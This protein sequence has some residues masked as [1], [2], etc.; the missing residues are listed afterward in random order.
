MFSTLDEIIADAPFETNSIDQWRKYLKPGRVLKREGTQFP[1]KKEE[2]DWSLNKLTIDPN[3]KFTKEE[4][5]ELVSNQR[6][7]FGV[8]MGRESYD[9]SI[10]LVGIGSEDPMPKN[11]MLGETDVEIDVDV[12]PQPKYG[13]DYDSERLHHK[14][15]NSRYEES[16]TR[17]KGLD[18]QSHFDRDTL[19][20]SRTSTH[21]AP[22][23][24]VTFKNHY[25]TP[26]TRRI[27]LVEEIQT[28]LHSKA[29]KKILTDPVTG[30]FY[31]NEYYAKGDVDEE[32][33]ARLVTERMGYADEDAK[34]LAK[35]MRD[36]VKD[37]TERGH[38]SWN[39]P[40]SPSS[41][42]EKIQD[43]I[44]RLQSIAT[45]LEER[46]QNA[47][48][49]NPGD[50][51]GLE[52]KKQ[53]LNAVD[54]DE[55]Y[56]AITRGMDQISRYD[57]A[58]DSQRS[59]G[60][61]KMYDEVYPSELKKLAKRYGATMEDVEISVTTGV[62]VRPQSMV[63][64]DAENI[65]EAF[66]MATDYMESAGEWMDVAEGIDDYERA[67]HHVEND[68][69]G[70]IGMIANGDELAMKDLRFQLG[71]IRNRL[72]R[73][74]DG[75]IADDQIALREFQRAM[76]DFSDVHR[77]FKPIYEGYEA[78]R[79]GDVHTLK[80]FPAMKL[81]PEVKERIR[82]LG[83]PQFQHGGL[84]RPDIYPGTEY[85]PSTEEF[86]GMSE[87]D[88]ERL[89]DIN[90][91]LSGGTPKRELLEGMEEAELYEDPQYW[92]DVPKHGLA[93]LTSMWKTLD[94]E[95]GEAEWNF[96]AEPPPF[97]LVER[98]LMPLS[99]WKEMKEVADRVREEKPARPGIIDETITMRALMTEIA[100]L[101]RDEREEPPQYA[102]EA[103]ERS[104]RLQEAVEEGM[105]LDPAVGFPQR[106]S[107]MMGFMLGQIPSPK[108][109]TEAT[110]AALVK[111]M[112][113]VA[114][115][116]PKA[117]KVGV[118]APLE[119]IDPTIRPSAATY[120]TGAAAGTGILYGI[121]SVAES[122]LKELEEK[123]EEEPEELAKGGSVTK[124]L[125]E[126]R[127]MKEGVIDAEG[128]FAAK[129]TDQLQADPEF[130]GWLDDFRS[131]IE[132]K[133][134][135]KAALMEE[136][137]FSY[138]PGDVVMG[139]KYRHEILFKTIDTRD[140]KPAY[141][142]KN[143]DDESQ[144]VLP[145]RGIVGRF[146]GPK[147]AEL[148]QDLE[149]VRLDAMDEFEEIWEMSGDE[150][151]GYDL[152]KIEITERGEGDKY[153][154]K[155]KT[156]DGDLWF[157]YDVSETHPGKTFVWDEI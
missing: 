70:N 122:Q 33:F 102:A 136:L 151:H 21:D 9:E 150:P 35:G 140:G 113:K 4:L 48:Y 3:Q 105:G 46:P 36:E 77:K 63:E 88:L 120:L 38:K 121:E 115:K 1:L 40:D 94:Q 55:D 43:E 123:L 39:D 34:I 66:D 149:S 37:L 91:V 118:G 98:G 139:E 89:R 142:V 75:A 156:P 148:M 27:R 62:D 92:K 108:S 96:G 15:P 54:N 130:Q 30:K 87:P 93:A 13:D 41:E 129:R 95:T 73:H 17:M 25:E 18:E 5:R 82:E 112:P 127:K 31:R 138:E 10:N 146:E 135:K 76:G 67:L 85:I 52:L 50:Y 126:L 143:L 16:V 57:A 68:M 132:G 141:H 65:D 20:W 83:V 53:L 154:G 32:G 79:G 84:V 42:Y 64:L 131:K 137:D 86:S 19:S 90:Y 58:M 26:M 133:S 72:K 24:G 114:A 134:A 23:P 157:T 106:F 59:I 69:E 8:T 111:M 49:K 44:E 145:E 107:Q 12:M 101:F 22:E 100:N 81:T 47:P 6:P 116:I 29:A 109:L 60:M 2:L 28:D 56:L 144:Y 119:F 14:S 117:V 124:A 125:K 71:G 110:G 155:L 61:E 97:E 147:D 153:R 128:V 45:R 103:M 104:M 11:W 51:A 152:E 74:F 99:E 80:D 7:M 78:F